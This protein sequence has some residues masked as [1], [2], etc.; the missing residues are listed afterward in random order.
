MSTVEVAQLGGT[1]RASVLTAE[2]RKTCAAAA[3]KIRWAGYVP[4]VTIAHSVDC[5][6]DRWR[7]IFYT[8]GRRRWLTFR[9][10]KLANS[11][12]RRLRAIKQ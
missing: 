3:L 7:V 9:D 11:E 10:E 6:R 2:E 5:G 12:A 8:N 4:K 1:A